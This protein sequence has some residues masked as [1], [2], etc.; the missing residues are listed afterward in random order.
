MA[1]SLQNL[2][3]N[4]KRA[5]PGIVLSAALFTS[6]VTAE[7]ARATTVSAIGDNF[8]VAFNSTPTAGLTLNAA[9][10]FTVTAFSS[11]A[12][13]FAVTISNNS[14]YTPASTDRLDLTALGF[15][16]DPSAGGVSV[17]GGNDFI[18]AAFASVPS[19]NDTEICLYVGNNCAGAGN[20]GLGQGETDNL[21]LTLTSTNFGSALAL[22]NFG[23]KFQ[24]EVG[25]FEFYGIVTNTPPGGIPASVGEPA[26][27]A[28]V[29]FGLFLLAF[30]SRITGTATR[31]NSRISLG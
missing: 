24:T 26:N 20:K 19:L 29:A 18:H 23:V 4:V 30:M 17:N 1:F 11:T 16:T 27:L 22:D 21:T 15:S 7:D 5:L 12:I 13:D 28:L 25:S 2:K 3:K 10:T 31:K 14:F 9:A 8:S 6:F